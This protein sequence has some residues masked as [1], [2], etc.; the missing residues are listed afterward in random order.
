MVGLAGWGPRWGANQCLADS[1]LQLLVHHRLVPADVDR[2]GLCALNRIELESDE[3]TV[4][5]SRDG[6]KDP[7]G[8]L[9]HNRHAGPSLQ[10]FLQVFYYRR[11]EYN[12]KYLMQI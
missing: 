3:V 5:R 10:F 4:P 6:V 11:N 2:E 1:L 8:F 7:G 9:E 12:Q